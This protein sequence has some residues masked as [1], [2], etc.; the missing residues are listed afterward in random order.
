M[1]LDELNKAEHQLSD[2][3]YLLF[4]KQLRHVVARNRG[5]VPPYRHWSASAEEREEAFKRIK[6]NN[7]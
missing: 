1:T 5:F 3:E 6:E 4:A 7:E 2:A